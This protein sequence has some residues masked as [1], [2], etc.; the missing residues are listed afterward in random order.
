VARRDQIPRKPRLP[1]SAGHPDFYTPGNAVE[2][3]SFLG[4]YR[5]NQAAAHG[6]ARRGC[7]SKDHLSADLAARRAIREKAL[8]QKRLLLTEHEAKA[9][10]AAFGLPCRARRGAGSGERR[11]GGARDRLPGGVK[12]HFPTSTHK[13]DVGACAWT[14][15]TPTWSPPRSTRCMRNVNGIKPAARVEGVVVQPMLRL[16][17]LEGDLVA[18]RAMRCSVR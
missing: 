1:G 2:A 17:R 11:G 18:W 14:C 6:S 16:S 3:F 8:A 15:R 5:R 12:I 7:A 13:S 9:L 4:I 10:L